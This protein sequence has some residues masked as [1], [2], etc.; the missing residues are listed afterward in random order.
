MARFRTALCDLLG[1][2]YPILQSGMGGAAGPELVAEVSRAGGLGILAG[3]RLTADQL[4]ASIRRV[5]ELT[6]RPFGV[7]LWLHTE[8]L[9]PAD[10][11]KIPEATVR[12]VQDTLNQFRTRLGIAR[13]E[14]RPPG[15]PD[16]IA[17]AFEVILEERVPVW[18]IGLGNPDPA[19]VTRC[20][21]RGITIIAMVA[22]A[23]D[24]RAVVASGVDIVVAQGAEAGG[25]R[26]TWVKPAA[27][28]AA[29]IGTV[30]LVPQIVDAVNVPVVASGGIADGRGLVAALALGA[31][32]VLFGTRFVATR[33]ATV[34]EFWK[35]AILERS[36]G[37]TTVTDAI[38]GLYARYVR[39]TF[40]E[41]YAAS[42]APVFPA[43]VQSQAA[44]DI[45]QA[46]AARQE[47]DYF[48]MPTGQSMGLIHDLPGA[49]EVVEAIVR[50]ARAVLEKLPT[51]V[52]LS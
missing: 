42:G 24:A 34:P 37:A 30:T 25:H 3:L 35:K 48:P 41:E 14:G 6:D 19:W 36:G 46:A 29:Q 45:F 13:T 49:G 28:E 33:E 1:I 47:P 7:N 5:R 11:S 22:T 18:S 32:G 26:S 51:R 4:R 27:R 39:N 38:T 21:E 10:V 17:G 23:E 16:V 31:Q 40:T 15:V 9:P 52:T 50:E 44:Q 43:L 8:L 2:E 20:H 12:Q